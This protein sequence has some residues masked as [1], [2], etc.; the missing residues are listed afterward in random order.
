MTRGVP[1]CHNCDPNASNPEYDQYDYYEL[2]LDLQGGMISGEGDGLGWFYYPCKDLWIHWFDNGSYDPNGKTIL[3]YSN[4]T[5]RSDWNYAG[6]AEISYVWSTAN[7]SGLGNSQPP[8]PGDV[9]TPELHS[10]YIG[11]IVFNHIGV[12]PDELHFLGFD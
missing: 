1:H 7:W 8:L 9:P 2:D 12:V 4:Y 5:E 6:C 10:S 3:E 11:S